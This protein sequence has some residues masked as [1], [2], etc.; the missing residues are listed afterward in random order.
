SETGF[1]FNPSTGDSF[2]TNPVAAE[3]ILLMK[4]GKSISQV[5]ESILSKYEV[6]K[7]SLEKDVDDLL[8]QLKDHNLLEA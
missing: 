5:K 2:S 4:E 7:I 6:D 8:T 3:I 1:I